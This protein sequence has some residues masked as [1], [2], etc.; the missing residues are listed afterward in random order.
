MTAIKRIIHYVNVTFDYGIWY[1]RDSNDCLAEYSDVDWA[2]RVD[3][4]KKTQ[5]VTSTSK[6]IW[7]HG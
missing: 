3:D 6:T 2:R 4:R 5:E 1:S 7:C